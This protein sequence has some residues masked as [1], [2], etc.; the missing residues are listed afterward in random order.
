MSGVRVTYSGLIAFS[1]SMISV[2]T[3]LIFVIII[4]RK[5]SPDDLGL[6]ALIGSL[7]SYVLIIRP[8][9]NYWATRQL[10]RGEEVGKTAVITNGFFSV[11]AIPVY[12][13]LAF[14]FAFT[15]DSDL[16][17]L[18]LAS[19]LIP[20]LFFNG[21]LNSLAIPKRPQAVSYGLVIFETA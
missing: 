21:T 9:T 15:L 13:V 18:L 8:I 6:W 3:G 19:V 12:F 1:V 14:Y 10:A 7:V 11:A 16:N 4:T 17:V 2:I 20:I 5:L